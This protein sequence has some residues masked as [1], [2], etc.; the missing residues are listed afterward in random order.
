M[1]KY[2]ITLTP[3]D[4]FY[5]GGE[6]IFKVSSEKKP[7]NMTAEDREL[8]TFDDTF[9][10]YIVKSNFLPQQTSLLGMLRFL[11]LSN[12]GDLFSNNRIKQGKHEEAANLIGERSFN[13]RNCYEI[14]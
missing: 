3:I 9:G 2:L 12:N 7:E 11:I 14:N 6:T 1:S 13:L 4:K 5:F 8:K 10:S